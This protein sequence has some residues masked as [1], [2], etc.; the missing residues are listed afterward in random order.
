VKKVAPIFF[1][2][3]FTS[4]IHQKEQKHKWIN[5]WHTVRVLMWKAWERSLICYWNLPK[6]TSEKL[7]LRFHCKFFSFIYV[8]GHYT[9]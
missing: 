6:E 9:T 1:S 2:A 4:K 7:W 5:S 8:A 3:G